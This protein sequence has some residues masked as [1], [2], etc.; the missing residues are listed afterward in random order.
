MKDQPASA[1]LDQLKSHFGVTTD[2]D[3]A[4]KLEVD[5]RTVASWRIRDKV[6]ERIVAIL[7]VLEVSGSS[8]ESTPPRSWSEHDRLAF[9]LALFRLSRLAGPVANSSE[10]R[11][12]FD[13]FLSGNLFWAL[14]ARA[15]RDLV[16]RAD[17][18]GYPLH[19]ALALVLHDD[20]DDA[21][22]SK[23]RDADT[24]GPFKSLLDTRPSEDI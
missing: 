21:E 19:T 8:A 10:Y 22:V 5:K 9:G 14:H 15:K 24:L 2:T 3:L 18:G 6:P 16:S 13:L 12:V 11:R 23:R 7:K 17:E 20:M 4:A 1:V